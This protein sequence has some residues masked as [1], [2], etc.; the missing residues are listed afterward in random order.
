MLASER[1]GV[2]K[3]FRY[4]PLAAPMRTQDPTNIRTDFD[5][6]INDV[7]TAFE[8]AEAKIEDDAPRKLLAEYA[9][10]AAAAL[11]EGFISDLFVAY[12]NSDFERFRSHLLNHISTEA[13]DEY[14]KRAN[15][16]VS[17]SM[18]NLNVEQIRHVLD[19]TAFNVTFST[20]DKMKEAAGKWLVDDHKIRFTNTTSQ[21]CAVID[22]TKAVRNFLAHRSQA[23]DN[24]MQA[25]LVALDLPADLKRNQNNVADVGKHLRATQNGQQRF[26][27]FTDALKGLAQQF[28]PT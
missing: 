16:H 15:A 20:T 21:Q 27:H 7:V 17:M 5:A 14:A 10:V 18:P 12:I 25:A 22:F 26:K 23:S 2:A 1:S 11:L 24:S 28:C 3:T 8:A 13:S 19:P 9:F 4:T 6:A